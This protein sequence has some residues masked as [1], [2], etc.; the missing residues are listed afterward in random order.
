MSGLVDD[1]DK[2]AYFLL[3][4]TLLL[5]VARSHL[6]QITQQ[7]LNHPHSLSPLTHLPSPSLQ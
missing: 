2:P 7:N 6:L 4:S 3:V 1:L 5:D